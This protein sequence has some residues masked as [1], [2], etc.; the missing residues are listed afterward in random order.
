[1]HGIVIKDRR[2]FK[3]V[4]KN[5]QKNR[6]QLFVLLALSVLV[7]GCVQPLE[8]YN[9]K[10]SLEGNNQ[11]VIVS[12]VP[13][14]INIKKFDKNYNNPT[15]KSV[16]YMLSEKGFW[17][18]DFSF[19]DAFYAIEPGIYYISGA[20][21]TRGEYIYSTILAGL[22]PEG[23]VAYGAFEVREG[24]VAFLGKIRSGLGV[25][26][27]RANNP[28]L[29]TVDGNLEDAKKEILNSQSKYKFLV[30]KLHHITFYPMGS[31]IFLDK[32]G[33]YRLSRY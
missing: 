2:K 22:T 19:K 29:F 7:A 20:S 18:I 30:P 33:V 12:S 25:V 31:R 21:V 17:R 4:G 9:I 10:N 32:D 23:R 27:D 3:M 6:I 15:A 8:K 24:D 1:M 28:G 5:T 26:S 13:H 16:E 14:R 11:A